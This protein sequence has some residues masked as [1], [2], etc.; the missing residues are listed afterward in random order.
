[1]TTLIKTPFKKKR[2]TIAGGDGAKT[3]SPSQT[4]RSARGSSTARTNSLAS[5]SV[6]SCCD[7]DDDVCESENAY[8][9]PC[10][11][12]NIY[13]DIDDGN[14][15]LATNVSL[16]PPELP[17]AN[18]I[19][20]KVSTINECEQPFEQCLEINCSKNNLLLMDEH[21]MTS[22]DDHL[23]NIELINNNLDKLMQTQDM[24]EHETLDE[25][26][27]AEV[28]AEKKKL[29][30]KIAEK[31]KMLKEAR[32]ASGAIAKGSFK[33]RF[34]NILRQ[35]SQDEAIGDEKRVKKKFLSSFRKKSQSVDESEEVFEEIS[36]ENSQQQVTD[37][38]EEKSNEKLKKKVSKNFITSTRNLLSAKIGTKKSQKVK[39]CRKCSKSCKIFNESPV[40]DDFCACCHDDFEDDGIVIKNFEYKD[41]SVSLHVKFSLSYSVYSTIEL[42]HFQTR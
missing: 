11:S 16:V 30:E 4:P 28:R 17:Q 42:C 29:K 6:N 37:L 2:Q 35:S 24:I 36:K 41:V 25:T 39:V 1:M 21:V 38:D 20:L 32:N 8:V 31:I 15:E 3:R 14:D 33:S 26:V 10:N 27:S 22:I 23:N 19:P 9:V 7:D 12:N 13:V 40:E 5:S 34:K 18:H